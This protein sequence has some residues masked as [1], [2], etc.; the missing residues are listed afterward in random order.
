MARPPKRNRD[1]VLVQNAADEEQVEVGREKEKRD[2]EISDEDTQFVLK[3]PQG[4][5]FCARFI[6]YCVGEGSTFSSDPLMMAYL[7][8][9][10]D[11][12]EELRRLIQQVDRKAY[13]IMIMESE[14]ISHE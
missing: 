12:G 9:M 7:N 4:R 2:L 1:D 14:E 10:R 3:T 5:R 8:G 13:N 6:N 11:C